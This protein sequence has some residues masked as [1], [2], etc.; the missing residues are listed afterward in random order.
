MVAFFCPP[1]FWKPSATLP[2]FA[3]VTTL[4]DS[5]NASIYTFSNAAIGAAAAG[6]LVVVGVQGSGDT[7][8]SVTVAGVSATLMSPSATASAAIFGAVVNSGTTGDIVVTWNTGQLRTGIGV[9]ALYDL[10][11]TTPIDADGAETGT[12][13]SRSV[14]LDMTA[15]SIAVVVGRRNNSTI[16]IN[17]TNATERYD[18]MTESDRRAGADYQAMGA[19]TRTVTMNAVASIAGAAW[20]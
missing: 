19:E 15:N 3:Y 7:I 18:T 10:S 9:W 17:T 5:S 4:D 13:A 11:S 2:T 1:P 12:N 8:T 20:R 14:T 16:A 6:R